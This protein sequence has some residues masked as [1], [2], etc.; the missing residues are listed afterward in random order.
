MRNI[1]ATKEVS[2]LIICGTSS[3]PDKRLVTSTH[4]P[5]SLQKGGNSWV[6]ERSSFHSHHP[7][8]DTTAALKEWNK[9]HCRMR[10]GVSLSETGPSKKKNKQKSQDNSCF[11]SVTYLFPQIFLYQKSKTRRTGAKRTERKMYWRLD[12]RR[13]MICYCF[14]TGLRKLPPGCVLCYMVL[15]QR[16]IEKTLAPPVDEHH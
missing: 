4:A 11:K 9:C 10:T 2:G 6:R 15:R 8:M 12:Q 7:P 1:K 16:R 14:L 5:V 3:H 13:S